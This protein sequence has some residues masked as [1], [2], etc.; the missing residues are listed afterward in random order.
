[1]G[2]GGPKFETEGGEGDPGVNKRRIDGGPKCNIRDASRASGGVSSDGTRDGGASMV[3][4]ADGNK[5][6]DKKESGPNGAAATAVLKSSVVGAT[7][8]V[9]ESSDE[10]GGTE[11]KRVFHK[12]FNSIQHNDYILVILRAT[13]AFISPL[14]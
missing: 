9:A 3:A 5:I 6:L 7:R 11:E 1:M 14:L 8:N 2:K 13:K 12:Q 10:F 4:N